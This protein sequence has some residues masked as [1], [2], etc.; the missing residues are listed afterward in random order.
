MLCFDKSVYDT[1]T[2]LAECCKERYGNMPSYTHLSKII[3][4]KDI[5]LN[6][7]AA[8]L[9]ADD[10]S[11]LV[12]GIKDGIKGFLKREYHW[13]R[14]ASSIADG[15]SRTKQIVLPRTAMKLDPDGKEAKLNEISG[16]TDCRI[17]VTDERFDFQL[18]SITGPKEALPFAC[19]LVKDA[20]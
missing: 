4:L 2:T 20:L 1:L 15:P 16:K 14:P 18:L 11:K 8:N 17:R 7:A 5:R 12:E 9:S 10:T 19:S 6:S 13:E 3:F